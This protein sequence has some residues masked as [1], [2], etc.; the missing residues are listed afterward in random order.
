MR[1]HD[2]GALSDNR[3]PPPAT[4]P[5]PCSAP[6]N[7]RLAPQR[8]A[9]PQTGAIDDGLDQTGARFTGLPLTPADLADPVRRHTSE[10]VAPRRPATHAPSRVEQAG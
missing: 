1:G 7:G 8:Q 4:P 2:S 10:P 3:E 5:R 9:V 6:R